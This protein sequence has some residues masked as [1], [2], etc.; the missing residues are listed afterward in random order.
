LACLRGT[1]RLPH[2]GHRRLSRLRHASDPQTPQGSHGRDTRDVEPRVGSGGRPRQRD[3]FLRQ[4]PAS[5]DAGQCPEV[6]VDPSR[7]GQ[8]VE[9]AARAL[10]F[11]VLRSR[12]NLKLC[13]KRALGVRVLCNNDT[14]AALTSPSIQKSTLSCYYLLQIGYV[15]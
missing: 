6:R 7:T 3:Q 9:F 15:E 2:L 10:A 8:T 12:I 1:V 13:S 5:V 4:R 11:G 14:I